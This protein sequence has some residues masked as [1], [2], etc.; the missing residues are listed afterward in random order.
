[1]SS[2]LPSCSLPSFCYFAFFLH[3][4]LTNNHSHLL[5]I[6]L[7]IRPLENDHLEGPAI[8]KWSSGGSSH[9][10]MIIRRDRP[11]ANDLPKD[12][13]SCKWSSG[14]TGILQM[15]I[16]HPCHVNPDPESISRTFL[17]QFVLVS[18]FLLRQKER[19]ERQNTIYSL[20]RAPSREKKILFVCVNILSCSG[21]NWIH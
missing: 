4:F 8:C 1:M 3:I 19:P 2:P 14:G 11:F 7:R 16:R 21:L 17:E 18:C 6:I 10:Q 13:A 20:G 15:I 9:L 12:L 5:L